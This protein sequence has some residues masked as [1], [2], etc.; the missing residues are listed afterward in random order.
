MRKFV[1]ILL[2][3]LLIA[4]GAFYYYLHRYDY[5]F[6]LNHLSAVGSVVSVTSREFGDESKIPQEF[7]CDGS[8]VSPDISFIRIPADAK[9]LAIVLEDSSTGTLPFTHWILFNLSPDTTQI[10]SSKVIFNADLGTNDYGK[11]EYDGPCPPAGQTHKYYFKVFALDTLLEIQ[12]PNRSQ[13]NE[14]IYGHVLATGTLSGL[15]SKNP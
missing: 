12:N 13:F 9:S 5:E 14:E 7:T 8:N 2:G 1:P 4:V 15:Y 6:S 10:I 3:T 11:T